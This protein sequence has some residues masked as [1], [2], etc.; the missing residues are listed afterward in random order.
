[1][2]MFVVILSCVVAI[3]LIIS[4]VM[5]SIVTNRNLYCIVFERKDRKLWKFF[6]ENVNNFKVVGSWSN[7]STVL[8]YDGYK[9]WAWHDSKSTSVHLDCKCVLCGFDE[10]MSR[11]MYNTLKEL[12]K[13]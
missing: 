2:E 13:I 4:M 7:S 3:I 1:M 11:R 6:I 5:L 12:G 9:I 8:E 10:K